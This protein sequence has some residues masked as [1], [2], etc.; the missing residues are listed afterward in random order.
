MWPGPLTVRVPGRRD[1]LAPESGE[2]VVHITMPARR[3]LRALC[4]EAGPLA[5][6]PLL[7]ADGQAILTLE[8][9]RSRLAGSSV[10]LVVDGG[11]CNAPRPTVVDCT[12]MPPTVRQVGALP[13]SYVDAALMMGLRRRRWFSR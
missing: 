7:H 5:V 6:T 13:E 9:V 3:A 8:E 4:R 12:V 2:S 11:T 10:A 1:G